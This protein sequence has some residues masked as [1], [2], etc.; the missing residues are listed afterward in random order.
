MNDWIVLSDFDGT[1]SIQD[2]ND[3]L[4]KVYGNENN[5]LIEEQ[6]KRGILG[7]RRGM[8]L[9]FK[10]LS[11]SVA[12]Y[13]RFIENEIDIDNTFI[14]FSKW[15]KDR[16]IPLY[17]VSGGFTE[18]IGL[19]LDANDIE[20]RRIYA[21][22][23]VT[24]KNEISPRFFTSEGESFCND[25]RCGNCKLNIVMKYK[26]IGKKVVYI[27]DSHT[28]FCV[29]EHVDLLYAKNVLEKYCVKN[30]IDHTPYES[31]RDIMMSLNEI[32]SNDEV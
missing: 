23:L 26:K 11:I 27:G 16:E 24:I 20:I 21:N 30:V 3:L 13:L 14:E 12:K 6:F 8:A 32:W 18:A 17:V 19:V 22:Q 9:H 2:S 31:F 25:S 15:L 28:D 4:F 7:A 10:Y 1:I 29:S 5:A